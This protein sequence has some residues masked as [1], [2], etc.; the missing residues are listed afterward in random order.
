MNSHPD[1]TPYAQFDP[2]TRA[3]AA[4]IEEHLKQCGE[5]RD[6]VVFIRKTNATLQHQ[7]R[8]AR[9]AKA[10]GITVAKL[11]REIQ[12]GTSIAALIDRPPESPVRSLQPRPEPIAPAKK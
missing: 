8:I 6:R 5:C 10:L 11:K 9:V 7:G 1:I 2:I 4:R 3:E 12:L